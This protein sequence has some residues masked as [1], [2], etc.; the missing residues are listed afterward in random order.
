MET[1]LKR[2]GFVIVEVAGEFYDVVLSHVQKQTCAFDRKSGVLNTLA[3][4]KQ[5]A[6]RVRSLSAGST[7]SRSST[8]GCVDS[9]HQLR[10][11][12][13]PAKGRLRP[14][15]PARYRPVPDCRCLAL[16][17]VPAAIGRTSFHC[18]PSSLRRVLSDRS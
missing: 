6:D 16:R 2:H 18:G 1:R 8:A 7:L 10:L 9:E 12:I 15:R 5:L 3:R 11:W 4:L 13:V 14:V 17:H